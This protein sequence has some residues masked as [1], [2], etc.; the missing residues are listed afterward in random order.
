M[1]TIV[2]T[3]STRGIGYGLAEQFLQRGCRVAVSGR[4]EQAVNQAV[5][6]LTNKYGG[7]RVAGQ[8]CDVS[9]YEQ[10][11]KLWDAAAQRFG[12]V[13]VWIN[14][15]GISNPYVKFWEVKPEMLKAV[16]D[17]NL[18]GSLY[19]SHVALRGMLA[20]GGGQLY[21]MEGFGSD[22][23]VGD[24][25]TV[26]GC[27]KAA[28]R[29]L[30]KALLHDAKDTPV[31]IGTLSP[32]IVLTDLWSEL[33]DGQPERW[34]KAK[35]IVNILGDKVETVTPWLVE[36]VLANNKNGARIAW[37]TPGKAASRFMTAPFRKRDLFAA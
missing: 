28:I 33:Y 1:K 32:G 6:Q 26:Y 35:K 19:G 36:R 34:E 22:G 12:R 15:A 9:V 16:T 5:A 4:S 31:Q 27:T 10:A 30:N 3:G 20:Q 2:I 7:D 17:T 23:R 13:D 21:N 37:L 18:L 11:Q 14:N 29:Y 25:L 24:G 8:P